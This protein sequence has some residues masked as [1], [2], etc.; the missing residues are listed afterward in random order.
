MEVLFDLLSNDLSLRSD[1]I[2]GESLSFSYNLVMEL[3]SLDGIMSTSSSRI[4]KEPYLVVMSLSI[5][6]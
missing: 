5:L 4:L 3:F 1:L 2:P 6:K